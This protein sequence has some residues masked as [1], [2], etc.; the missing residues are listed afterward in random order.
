MREN[1]AGDEYIFSA[2]AL[3]RDYYKHSPVFRCLRKN[4]TEKHGSDYERRVINKKF[5]SY[6]IVLADEN[7]RKGE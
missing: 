4:A 6:L 2:C 5:M 3:M 1:N 7:R